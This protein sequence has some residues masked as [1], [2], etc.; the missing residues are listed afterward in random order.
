MVIARGKSPKQSAI[1]RED[2]FASLAMTVGENWKTPLI[3]PDWR[4]FSQAAQYDIISI[5]PLLPERG[6]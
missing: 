6:A 2:C 5:V 1:G 3:N 4:I